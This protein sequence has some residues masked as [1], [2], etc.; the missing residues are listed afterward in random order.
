MYEE[1]CEAKI[2]MLLF[3]RR[4]EQNTSNS[5][6]F[7]SVH[8]C[9]IYSVTVSAICSPLVNIKCYSCCA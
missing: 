9:G 1:W 7:P 4:L 8:L 5:N 3:S 2:E 6:L